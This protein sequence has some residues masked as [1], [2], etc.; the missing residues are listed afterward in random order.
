LRINA[1]VGLIE[2]SSPIKQL[3]VAVS[4]TINYITVHEVG[5]EVWE[6]GAADG[7]LAVLL[8]NS[9]YL[10]NAFRDV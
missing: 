7:E 1:I 2:A 9:T 4:D 10:Y 5:S 8:A 6:I 3:V